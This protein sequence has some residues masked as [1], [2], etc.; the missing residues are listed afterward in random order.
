[1]T[2]D[3]QIQRMLK[4][5]DETIPKILSHVNKLHQM[6][7][8]EEIRE[9]LEKAKKILQKKENFLTKKAEKGEI[10]KKILQKE[11]QDYQNVLKQFDAL[12]KSVDEEETFNEILT[13]LQTNMK[14]LEKDLKALQQSL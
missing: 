9:Y 8:D 4:T 10:N 12:E 14:Q 3:D 2:I 7:A 1:M 5:V 11:I 6:K 13:V